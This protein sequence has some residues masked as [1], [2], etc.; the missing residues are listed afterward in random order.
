M[1]EQ[2][3]WTFRAPPEIERAIEKAISAD[4]HA[5]S[6]LVLKVIPEWLMANGCPAR[7]TV[8]LPLRLRKKPAQEA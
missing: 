1:F 5:V 4:S 6:G 8:A 7:Q 3:Q 2:S